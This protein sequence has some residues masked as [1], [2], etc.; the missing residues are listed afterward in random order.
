MTFKLSKLVSAL[1]S[2]S[3]VPIKVVNSFVGPHQ[4]TGSV[5]FPSIQ[6]NGAPSLLE[7]PA[8]DCPRREVS[9]REAR[10]GAL[11]REQ[12]L[13]I[14]AL[15][16]EISRLRALSPSHYI[17]PVVPALVPSTSPPAYPS[18]SN[19]IA[20]QAPRCI[21]KPTI[22][23]PAIRA[24]ATSPPP[25]LL[26]LPK[27][28]TKLLPCSG[29]VL[30][31]LVLALHPLPFSRALALELAVLCPRSSPSGEPLS[32]FGECSQGGQICS[33]SRDCV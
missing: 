33:R 9:A 18:V 6:V 25:N 22:P 2:D 5:V 30:V 14:Q 28:L 29:P 32:Q 1:S 20:A 23:T 26:A 13:E 7:P 16:R 31:P 10:L 19:R 21:H 3:Q 12:F 24:L 27:A 15:Q 11:V 8:N 17:A 4:P